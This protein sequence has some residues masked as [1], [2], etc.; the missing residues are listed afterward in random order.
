MSSCIQDAAQ[1]CIEVVICR[2]DTG[3]EATQRFCD[4]VYRAAV[5]LKVDAARAKRAHISMCVKAVL[6]GSPVT[7]GAHLL[8]LLDKLTSICAENAGSLPIVKALSQALPGVWMCLFR[9][10]RWPHGL[11]KDVKWLS[12]ATQLIG[13]IMAKHAR[14]AHEHGIPIEEHIYKVLAV[15]GLQETETALLVSMFQ[16]F[17]AAQKDSSEEAADNGPIAENPDEDPSVSPGRA[18]ADSSTGSEKLLSGV[19]A[20]G[21]AAEGS[22]NAAETGGLS[23]QEADRAAEVAGG[24]ELSSQGG[25][26]TPAQQQE[27]TRPESGLSEDALIKIE[28]MKA[29]KAR[30]RAARAHAAA[31]SAEGKVDEGK[32]LAPA[33]GPST[34]PEQE[35]SAETQ[36]A[37]QTDMVNDFSSAAPE[38][39]P[40]PSTPAQSSEAAASSRS[41]SVSPQPSLQLHADMSHGQLDADLPRSAAPAAHT[42]SPAAQEEEPWQ[43]VRASRRK[44]V[45]QQPAPKASTSPKQAR[46]MLDQQSP[47]ASQ[48][49]PREFKAAA[50]QAEQASPSFD[51]PIAPLNPKPLHKAPEQLPV[52]LSA[53]ARSNPQPSTRLNSQTYVPPF[54]RSC[55]NPIC[56]QNQPLQATSNNAK[57]EQ[58]SAAFRQAQH[59]GMH[60]AQAAKEEDQDSDSLCVVCWEE[61]R[62]VIFYQ[63]MHMCTCQGCAKDIMAAGGPCPMCRAKI[64]STITARF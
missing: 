2:V 22:S 52:I 13:D 7:V 64:Q 6:H 8:E 53:S 45:S 23:Q 61:L 39:S 51:K 28:R 33:E 59:P 57:S 10:H 9:L 26:G 38:S 11:G 30:Q 31:D 49:R 5:A 46:D 35:R 36:A 18:P 19:E 40:A 60:S 17:W 15:P 47:A 25:P 44:P 58:T 1:Q 50:L 62:E 27:A 29:K 12:Q 55:D 16:D 14:S 3:E 41:S 54:R 43:E 20:E 42:P 32:Q 34:A 63:C 24:K 4:A 21:L 56:A 48:S 37:V